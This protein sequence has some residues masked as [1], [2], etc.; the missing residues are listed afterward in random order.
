MKK[1]SIIGNGAMA[2]DIAQ[3]LAQTGID[4]VVRGRSDEKLQKAAARIE[5]G[6]SRL[7]EKGRMTAEDKQSLIGRIKIGRAHV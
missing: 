7:V 4:V 5:K 6:T 1:I 2:M 3:V